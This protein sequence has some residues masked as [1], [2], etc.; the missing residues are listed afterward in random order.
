MIELYT[1]ST[2]PNCKT[3]K[4]R[5]IDAKIHFRE[6]NTDNETEMLKMFMDGRCTVP[7]VVQVDEDG[8]RRVLEGEELDD[9][10]RGVKI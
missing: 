4:Q 6:N 3:M 5:L 8:Y 1:A 7:T 2:C 10:I 9:F